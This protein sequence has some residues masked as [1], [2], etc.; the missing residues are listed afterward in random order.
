[1]VED[2]RS[3]V[4]SWPLTV[5]LCIYALMALFVFSDLMV[6]VTSTEY[7]S[8]SS[9]ETPARTSDDV[10]RTPTSSYVPH[11]DGDILNVTP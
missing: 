4:S 2:Y 10:V 11:K 8:V 7:I 3:S 1:M 9:L 5:S 6:H